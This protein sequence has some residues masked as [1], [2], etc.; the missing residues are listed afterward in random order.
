LRHLLLL[1]RLRHHQELLLYRLLLRTALH[2]SKLRLLIMRLDL[3][4]NTA[5]AVHELLDLCLAVHV[6]H[7]FP[8]LRR[9]WLLLGQV[10]RDRSDGSENRSGIPKRLVRAHVHV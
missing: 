3:L 7:H 4:L 5:D 1:H 8:R 6:V 9:D 10:L 2:S